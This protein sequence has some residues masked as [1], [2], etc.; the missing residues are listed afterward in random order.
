M[1]RYDTA[2]RV[3]ENALKNLGWESERISAKLTDPVIRQIADASSEQVVNIIRELE[4]TRIREIENEEDVRLVMK[5]AD[6]RCSNAEC[7]HEMRDEIVDVP[8][9]LPLSRV[10]MECSACGHDAKWF[11]PHGTRFAMQGEENAPREQIEAAR[12]AAV[13]GAAG[14]VEPFVGE[15]R[16]EL[17]KWEQD[18][19]V[20]PMPADEARRGKATINSRTKFTQTAEF[21]EQLAA[22]I[23][24]ASEIA[25][26]GG[27]R[28]AEAKAAI[29]QPNDYDVNSFKQQVNLNVVDGQSPVANAAIPVASVAEEITA[30]P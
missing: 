26:A 12:L 17:R 18:N 14:R 9:G 27:D 4:E 10:T 8:E 15:T 16:S 25:E 5:S 6:F 29:G 2:Y 28:L 19:N 13:R 3:A 1:K 21:E 22:T 23:R 30:T 11:I 7:G 24:T 20:S